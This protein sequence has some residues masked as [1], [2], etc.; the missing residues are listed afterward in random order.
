MSGQLRQT[1]GNVEKGTAGINES[2][3]ALKHNFL[4]RGYFRKQAK[5]KAQA[6]GK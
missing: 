1:L 3:E 5:K 2:V 4:L 6:A